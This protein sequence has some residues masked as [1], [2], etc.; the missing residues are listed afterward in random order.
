MVQG[1]PAEA[2][3]DCAAVLAS[4]ASAPGTVCFAQLLGATGQLAQGERL[5]AAL[6]DRDIGRSPL[7]G[8]ALWVMADFADRRGDIASAERSL[9]AALAATPENEGVRSAL[10]DLLLARGAAREAMTLLDLPAPS[11][12]LLARK[13]HAQAQLHDD[14]LAATRAQIDEL[15]TLASRRGER[16]HLRE[17]A[18][19]ALDVEH[20]AARALELAKRNFEIQRET[21]DARLLVRAARTQGDAVALA[22]VSRWL[23][24]THFEDRVLTG[25]GT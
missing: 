9:H 14:R 20:D 6:I 24:E 17:E 3:G 16:P 25:L 23:R 18:L 8:W 11:V 7:R 15:L 21:I 19:L 22:E 12:G 5:L 10:V 2:R 1:R 4:G 13:A